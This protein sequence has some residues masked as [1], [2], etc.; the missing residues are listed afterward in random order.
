MFE[1]KLAHQEEAKRQLQRENEINSAIRCLTTNFYLCF[2]FLVFFIMSP[3][4]NEMVVV[5]VWAFSKAVV[6]VIATISNFVK[7]HTLMAEMFLSFKSKVSGLVK[8]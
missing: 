2:I 3:F 5:V 6:P 7:I 1:L 4:V 8:W